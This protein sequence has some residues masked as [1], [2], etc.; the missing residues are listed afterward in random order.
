M[1]Y[2]AMYAR[3]LA[4]S[5]RIL[6]KLLQSLSGLPYMNVVLSPFDANKES[7]PQQQ[8]AHSL[9][10]NTMTVCVCLCVCVCCVLAVSVCKPLYSTL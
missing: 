4:H 5:S 9:V 2:F 8:K 1:N 3:L 7:F 10:H 6:N